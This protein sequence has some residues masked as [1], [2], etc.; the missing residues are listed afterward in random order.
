[1]IYRQ[2]IDR[3]RRQRRPVFKF[4]FRERRAGFDRRARLDLSAVPATSAPTTQHVVTNI[5]PPD[6]VAD[7]M[8][9]AQLQAL[10]S[11]QARALAQVK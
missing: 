10:G 9:Y 11:F 7:T 8:D 5:A 2:V 4:L 3:R 6:L 1:V